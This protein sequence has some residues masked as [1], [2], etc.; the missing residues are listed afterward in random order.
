MSMW[1]VVEKIPLTSQSP[2][3]AKSIIFLLHVMY[4]GVCQSLRQYGLDVRLAKEGLEGPDEVNCPK[5]VSGEVC[6][7]VFAELSKRDKTKLELL[8]TR[9]TFLIMIERV[10]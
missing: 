3:G 2:K 7:Q 8:A 4:G 6:A 10:A 9:H 5:V 1:R